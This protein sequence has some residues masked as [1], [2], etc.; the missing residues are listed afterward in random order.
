MYDS[1]TQIEAKLNS[2]NGNF[3]SPAASG[4]TEISGTPLTSKS[5]L[6]TTPPVSTQHAIPTSPSPRIDPSP[7]TSSDP[8]T[9]FLQTDCLSNVDSA[10]SKTDSDIAYPSTIRAVF[11]TIALT[12]ASFPVALDRTIVAPAM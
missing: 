7:N 2:E 5:A 4:T 9:V 3:R 10:K 6:F 1:S 12:L 8:E 11:I